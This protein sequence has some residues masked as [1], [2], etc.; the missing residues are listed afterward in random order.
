MTIEN[1][2]F[3]LANGLLDDAPV[4]E[5]SHF[6]VLMSQDPTLLRA[7]MVV[8]RRHSSTPFEMDAAEWNDLPIALDAARNSLEKWSPAGYTLGWNV[9]AVGGQTVDH[10][11]LHVIG[12]FEDD[13]M[14]GRGFR[15][16]LKQA[17]EAL[18]P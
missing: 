13:P 17:P 14:A 8:P 4:H 18:Q 12:R 3:C 7:A 15:H 10:A 9:G 16:P 1:C 5:T 6:Y 11:H 2:R